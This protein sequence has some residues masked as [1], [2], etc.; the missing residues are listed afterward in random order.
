[1]GNRKVIESQNSDPLTA[2]LRRLKEVVFWVLAMDLTLL[3]LPAQSNPSSGPDPIGLAAIA[4]MPLNLL[5]FSALGGVY[6]ILYRRRDVQR[7]EK[8]GTVPDNLLIAGG[9][10]LKS[11]YALFLLLVICPLFSEWAAVV[12]FG[13]LSLWRMVQML[14][15]SKD[16]ADNGITELN[17]IKGKRLRVCATGLF[18]GFII[19][20]VLLFTLGYTGKRVGA[21]K[22]K[23]RSNMRDSQ[24]AVE[25]YATNHAGLYPLSANDVGYKSYFSGG[26]P[27]DKP[28]NPPVNPVTGEPQWPVDGH[29][30]DVDTARRSPAIPVGK[31]VVEYSVIFDEKQRPT[32]YA[33]RGGN[34]DGSP[35]RGIKPESVLVLSNR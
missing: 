20:T 6:T 14:N 29:I 7:N 13:A 19:L 25:S 30:T 17:G 12:V 21:A 22:N 27:P 16:C 3:D 18:L 28:G 32:S 8:A 4:L 33:I 9:W 5:V 1:M 15:W 31:G 23:I 10:L 26:Q 2:V 24:I 35:A 34:F 11:F